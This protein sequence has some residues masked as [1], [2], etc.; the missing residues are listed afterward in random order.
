[1]TD[2]VAP[3]FPFFTAGPA[4]GA[5]VG[6]THTVSMFG[7]WA[8]HDYPDFFFRGTQGVWLTAIMMVIGGALFGIL[9]A[10]VLSTALNAVSRSLRN[11]IHF[12]AAIV[13]TTIVSVTTCE[14]SFQRSTLIHPFLVLAIIVVCAF[15]TGLATGQRMKPSS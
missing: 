6:L 15:V 5:V 12:S 2:S 11:R 13:A 8:F 3:P 4:I 10:V 1:M 7:V 9:Y 14:L